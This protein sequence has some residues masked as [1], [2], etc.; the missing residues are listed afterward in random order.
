MQC[1]LC[2]QHHLHP[3]AAVCAGWMHAWR[4]P[5]AEHWQHGRWLHVHCGRG[6]RHSRAVLCVSVLHRLVHASELSVWHQRDGSAHW[7]HVSGH[8]LPHW[9]AAGHSVR[10]HR[11]SLFQQ[12]LQ[13]H[14]HIMLGC[15]HE[16]RGHVR[17]GQLPRGGH[18]QQR[19]Q[20]VLYDG[21]RSATGAW[22]DPALCWR[23][24]MHQSGSVYI[25]DW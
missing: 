14:C 6:G 4:V 15:D 7:L 24:C 13:S 11:L 9:A 19:V 8:W 17:V 2:V 12:Q 25:Y 1:A 22:L 3:R 18:R 5:C 21:C 20:R 16:M 10:H 23:D